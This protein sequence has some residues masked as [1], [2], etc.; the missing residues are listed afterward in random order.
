MQA[1]LSVWRLQRDSYINTHSLACSPFHDRFQ[2]CIARKSV[3][4]RMQQNA[5]LGVIL[6]FSS[7]SH[8]TY[9]TGQVI[10]VQYSRPPTEPPPSQC[11]DV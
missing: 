8:F 4:V 7:L 5:A 6:A 1:K 2:V 9:S 3:T 11:N 10:V